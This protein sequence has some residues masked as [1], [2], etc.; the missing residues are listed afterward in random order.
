MYFEID[1]EDAQNMKI[2]AQVGG[3]GCDLHLL[4]LTYLFLP[5]FSL[6]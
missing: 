1:E 2:D 4:T 5:L 6:C 3:W